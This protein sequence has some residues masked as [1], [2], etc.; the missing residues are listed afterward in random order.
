M[1]K[2]TIIGAGPGGLYLANQ[3]STTG[4]EVTVYEK[5]PEEDNGG[6]G[7]TIS[8]DDM[9]IL[10][11]ICPGRF[12][13]HASHFTPAFRN[14][15]TSLGEHEFQK[16]KSFDI[17]G[18][19]RAALVGYLS[20]IAQYEGTQVKY[21]EDIDE[22]RVLAEKD[23]CD[24]L[25]GADGARSTVRSA[26]NIGISD[27]ISK[28]SFIWLPLE[29][30]LTHLMREIA[31]YGDELL[32][33]SAYPDSQTS[34]TAVVEY[35]G[36]TLDNKLADE[37][38]MVTQEGIDIFNKLFASRLSPAKFTLHPSKWMNFQG[39]TSRKT[40]K[41]NVY[42]IGDAFARIHYRTG[43][44]AVEAMYGAKLLLYCIYNDALSS[45]DEMLRERMGPQIVQ[46]MHKMDHL[47]NMGRAF[48]EFGPNKFFAVLQKGHF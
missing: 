15:T 1:A 31:P 14:T 19:K 43:A 22:Q 3:L 13:K 36:E 6:L 48:K 5:R 20:D 7:I 11:R 39:V 33:M 21:C 9:K 44:G 12:R 32:Y 4:Q 16:D 25:I 34:S 24:V 46:S 40:H 28:T 42:L 45:F 30:A 47:D 23:N 38:R 35:S 18:V 26:L 41:E 8:A 17:V 27:R 29:G 2:I 10:E 37:N